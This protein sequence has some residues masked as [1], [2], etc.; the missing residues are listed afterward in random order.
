M[1]DVNAALQNIKN[2]KRQLATPISG[3][4]ELPFLDVS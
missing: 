4:G 3:N 2:A 1:T